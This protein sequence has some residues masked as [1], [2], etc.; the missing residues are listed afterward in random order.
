MRSEYQPS[1]FG[2]ELVSTEHPLSGY[3]HVDERLV[4]VVSGE[5]LDDRAE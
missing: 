4:N 3:K 1:G 2:R 5:V